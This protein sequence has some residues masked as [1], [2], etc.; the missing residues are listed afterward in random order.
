MNLA[1][2]YCDIKKYAPEGITL[3]VLVTDDSYKATLGIVRSLGSRG[4]QVSVLADSPVTFAS[5]SRYCS[6]RY[7][8]SSPG[9]HA[10]FKSIKELL[11][12]VHFDLVIPVGY[13][14]TSAMA[15]YKREI[16]SLTQMEIS[17]YG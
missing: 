13:V 7:L 5:K 16:L 1:Q 12:R 8:V 6:A 9:S 11:R 10:F 4:I 14:M 2:F 3:H 15:Q 17:D